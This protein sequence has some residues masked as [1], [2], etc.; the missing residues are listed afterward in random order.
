MMNLREVYREDWNLVGSREGMLK[1]LKK[2]EGK[3][4]LRKKMFREER[5]LFSEL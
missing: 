1:V 3:T 2:D 4:R 5:P